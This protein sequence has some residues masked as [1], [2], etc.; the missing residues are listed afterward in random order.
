LITAYLAP[1]RLIP[2]LL[3][4]SMLS[5]SFFAI[6]ALTSALHFIADSMASMRLMDP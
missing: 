5:V 2:L 6:A 1:R 3:K 4:Q